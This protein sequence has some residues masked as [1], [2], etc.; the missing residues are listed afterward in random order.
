MTTAAPLEGRIWQRYVAL[1]DSFTE[2]LVDPTDDDPDKHHGWAD[3][4]AARLALRNAALVDEAGEPAPVPFGYANLAIRGRLIGQVTGEQ[5]E[6]GLTLTPDLVSLNAGGN[7]YLRPRVDRDAVV[8]QLEDAVVRIRE[9]GADVL[10]V[11]APDISRTP[12]LRRASPRFAEFTANVWGIA[13]RYDCFVADIWTLRSLR[14]AR[15][16][17]PDRIHLSTEGHRRVAQQAAWTLGLEVEGAAERAWDEPLAPLPPLTRWETLQANREWAGLHLR[18]WIQR[19]LT[20]RSSG[21]GRM[22]KRPTVA[23]VDVDRLREHVDRI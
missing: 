9:T 21:D 11:T 3:R 5:L 19:R 14:D 12:V 22:P 10:L 15:M 20:G 6:E 8:D 7:D 17:A 4:L 16:W 2:G 13:Q 23:Q 18:P 1:G